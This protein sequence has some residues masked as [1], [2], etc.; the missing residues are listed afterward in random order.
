[1][2]YYNNY[3]EE[4][5]HAG[6]F[7]ALRRRI[8][9]GHKWLTRTGT[10]GHYVYTYAKKIGQSAGKLF[11]SRNRNEKSYS[12]KEY[13]RNNGNKRSDDGEFHYPEHTYGDK[14]R[15]RSESQS[16][17]QREYAERQ[18]I[19]DRLADKY[20]TARGPVSTGA[21]IEAGSRQPRRVEYNTN[22]TG[23]RRNDDGSIT[24]NRKDLNT[25]RLEWH[26]TAA[27]P[28]YAKKSTAD[29]IKEW[30]ANTLSSIRK[31]ANDA[32]GAVSKGY[33]SAKN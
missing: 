16:M 19:E 1:M 25:G 33:E 6:L 24:Y 13:R 20:G 32:A 3:Y 29:R 7:S 26:A 21:V 14:Q 15:R 23:T 31:T 10:P 11:G 9:E 17:S 27:N 4:L 5:Y 30:G 2:D 28:R 18:K 22:V 12:R 8:R